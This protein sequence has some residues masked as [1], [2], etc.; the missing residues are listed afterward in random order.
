M[1][2]Y[3]DQQ[4]D[5]RHYEDN[6]ARPQKETRSSRYRE[7]IENEDDREQNEHYFQ[8]DHS[9]ELDKKSKYNTQNGNPPQF[10]EREE[11][12]ELNVDVPANTRKKNKR[13]DHESS[14]PGVTSN[15][16]DTVNTNAQKF[17][18][19]AGGAGS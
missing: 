13:D 14:K 7:P 12:Q 1:Q 17:N 11:E 9:P 10:D 19:T 16:N 2:D 3:Q 6:Q 18:V 15:Q 8:N 5:D 4:Q